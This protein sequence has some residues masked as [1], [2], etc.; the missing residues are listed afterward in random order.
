MQGP[1]LIWDGEPDSGS[2]AAALVAD[3]QSH[4]PPAGAEVSL[5]RVRCRIELST[6]SAWAFATWTLSAMMIGIGLRGDYW[7]VLAFAPFMIAAAAMQTWGKVAVVIENARLSVF[8]GVGSV[9]R[10]LRAPLGSIRRIEY[11]VKMHPR[12]GSSTTW[13]VIE[14][15][16]RDRKFGRYLSD[17]QI[18][19]VIAFLLD[20]MRSVS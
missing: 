8:E 12:N 7:L 18:R 2:R 15:D 13:I 5:D 3:L 20:A 16:G 1:Q 14:A 19:F 4:E 9:G 17:E 10:R 6:R 11:V